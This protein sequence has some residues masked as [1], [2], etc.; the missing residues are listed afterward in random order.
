MDD[1]LGFS[2]QEKK[3]SDDWHP[4]D[5]EESVSSVTSKICPHYQDLQVL[6][7]VSLELPYKC[8]LQEPTD[9]LRVCI[10]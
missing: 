1:T 5:T 6:Q 7:K 8:F 3:T 2:E 4:G 9:D 10:F